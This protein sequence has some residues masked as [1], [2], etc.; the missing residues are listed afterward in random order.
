VGARGKTQAG[1]GLNGNTSKKWGEVSSG[2]SE[3][4]I[5]T[6]PPS[7][8]Y[9]GGRKGG[10]EIQ[11]GREKQRSVTTYRLSGLWKLNS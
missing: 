6:Y 3:T 9:S 10:A 7:R 2:S 5:S 4:L 1:F 8:M 11:K